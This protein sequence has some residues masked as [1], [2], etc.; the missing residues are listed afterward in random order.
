LNLVAGEDFLGC[1]KRHLREEVTAVLI[2]ESW[3]GRGNEEI[4]NG[5]KV[6]EYEG[7]LLEVRGDGIV[8]GVE[9]QGGDAD[10]STTSFQKVRIPF[11]EEFFKM[12]VYRDDVLL[13]SLKV[14]DKDLCRDLWERLGISWPSNMD[15]ISSKVKGSNDFG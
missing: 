7:V 4:H 6:K 15:E 1:L 12:G 5:P 13:K 3:E 10:S 9:S 2:E 14:G 8:L 11:F